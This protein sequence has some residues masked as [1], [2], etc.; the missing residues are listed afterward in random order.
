MYEARLWYNKKETNNVK[1]AKM[2]EFIKT[3]D[4]FCGSFGRASPSKSTYFHRMIH[5]FEMGGTLTKLI[6]INR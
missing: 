2:V 6:E 1:V 4:Q 5:K 3:C